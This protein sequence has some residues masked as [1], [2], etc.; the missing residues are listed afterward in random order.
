MRLRS[1]LLLF[2]IGIAD[3]GS[4]QAEDPIFS[5]PQVGEKLPSF[6][7]RGVYGDDAGKELDFVGIANGKPIVL[8]FVHDATRPSIAMTRVLT[9]YTIDRTKDGLMTGVVWLQ[10]DVT[11][12]ENTLKRVEHALTPNTPTGVSTD[13]R[14]GPGSYGL[15]RN[16]M[17]TILVGNAGIVTSNFT[18]VQPSLQSDLPKVLESIVAVAG[19]KVPRLDDLQGMPEQMKRRVIPDGEVNMRPLL[20]PLIRKGA[21]LED[22][23]KAAM[24]VEAFVKENEAGQKEIGRTTNTIINAGKLANYGTPRAQEYLQ[25]WAKSYPSKADSNKEPADRSSTSK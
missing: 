7:V 19:G 3:I 23:D 13:G 14:E 8:I 1:L 6:K 11:E 5:G 20:A 25:K 10:D 22:V 21:T 17:L 18:L 4:L 24:A 12:A 9:Q 16:V 2:V 15:N